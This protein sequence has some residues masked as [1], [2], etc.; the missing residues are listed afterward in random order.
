MSPWFNHL[1]HE[2]TYKSMNQAYKS[3][4]QPTSLWSNTGV[5]KS[6]HQPMNPWINLRV[7]ESTHDSRN[8]PITPLDQ[9]MCPWINPWVH[10]V[11]HQPM[12]LSN[13]LYSLIIQT[14]RHRFR[15]S[16]T[17]FVI[18]LINQ[19]IIQFINSCI[20]IAVM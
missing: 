6:T 1:V 5:R 9:L 17:L 19:L 12:N 16:I 10:E 18:K 3:I 4:N 14:I 13:H 7:H 20:F 11:T 8:Q 15:Q 2:S